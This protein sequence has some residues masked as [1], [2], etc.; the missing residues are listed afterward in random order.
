MISLHKVG[1]TLVLC[2]VSIERLSCYVNLFNIGVDYTRLYTF[3]DYCM[4][5]LFKCLLLR[6]S[7][8]TPQKV[9]I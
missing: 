5:L 4:H 2:L 7:Q 1:S 9:K 6:S 8:L 3:R